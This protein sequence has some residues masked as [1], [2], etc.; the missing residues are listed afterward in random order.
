[1]PCQAVIGNYAVPVL[2]DRQVW[3]T[4][5]ETSIAYLDTQDVARMT[6]AALRND[7]TIG[8]TLTLAGPKAYTTK[9]VIEMCEDLSDSR[10]QVGVVEQRRP[11]ICD[12]YTIGHDVP[13]L[14]G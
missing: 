10:A 14:T 3:G 2:E 5:T 8:K 11:F 7:A 6:M 13:Y 1:M 4:D 9:E 12:L